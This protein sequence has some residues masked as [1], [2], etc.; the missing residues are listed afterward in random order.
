MSSS[1]RDDA[2]K[3][4]FVCTLV[5]FCL[6]SLWISQAIA[7]PDDTDE[8]AIGAF[9]WPERET[10][11]WLTTEALLWRRNNSGGSGPIIGG[12]ETFR[13]GDSNYHYEGGYRVGFGWLIDPNYEMEGVWTSMS[14]WGTEQTGILS[15]AISFDDGQASLFVDPTGDANFVDPSTFFRPLFD[16]ATD[17]DTV[18]LGVD[19][20]TDEFEFMQ[21]GSTYLLRQ[22]SNLYDAQ[23]NIKSRRTQGQRFGFGLGF[24]HVSLSEAALARIQGTFDAFDIDGDELGVDDGNDQL[25]DSALQRAGLS[26]I[27]GGGGIFD[28]SLGGA[29]FTMQ[30]NGTSSNQLNG[31]Q[32]LMD[33]S[34]IEYGNISIDGLVRAG[35]YHNRVRG[36]VTETYADAVDS[37]YRRTFEDQSDKLS[38][39]ASLGLTTAIRISER[40][41]LRTG[42][43]A[44]FLT[45]TA[46]GPS[47]QQGLVYD[48]LGNAS[49]SVQAADTLILHG[50]RAGLEMEW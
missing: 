18:N 20:E 22:S 28:P 7:Q 38:F 6:S 35:V 19:D 43:E 24:R 41:R 47:Q 12:P 40:I 49:Y 46:L 50:L 15:R 29:G 34:I 27:S 5:A 16:S 31:I 8:E 21:P 13:F 9:L 11:F 3:S 48:A 42:Y 2:M 39:G 25:S 36:A 26:L 37:V 23:L 1:I 45:N 17:P 32:A 14:G 10:G 44:M 30:W 33:A 4:P